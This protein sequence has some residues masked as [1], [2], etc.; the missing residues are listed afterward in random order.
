MINNSSPNSQ[1]PNQNSSLA[2]SDNKLNKLSYLNRVNLEYVESLMGQYLEN[3]E[4]V[5]PIWQKFFEGV[6][7][8]QSG[9]LQIGEA[10]DQASPELKVY[11]LIQAYRDY[12]HLKADLDPLKLQNRKTSFLDFKSFNLSESD[13]S[14]TFSMG[15]ILGLGP[16]TLSE[17]IDQLEKWYCQTLTV[18]MAECHP[19]VRDWFT[20]EMESE[21]VALSKD[22]KI[23]VLKQLIRTETLEKF[24]HTRYVGTKRFSIEGCDSLIPCLEYLCE[25]GAGLGVKAVTIGMAHRGRINVLANFMDK[26]LNIIFAEFDGNMG[27]DQT[28]D[29]DG[30][31]KYHL[32]YHSIKETKNGP[33]DISLAFNPSHLEAVNPVVLGMVRAQQ[34]F[35]HD[36]EERKTVV[37]VLIHGD[38]AVIGQG[39]VSETFQLSLL[40][41]YTVGGTIHIVMNNQVGFTTDPKDARSTDYASDIAKSIKAPILHVNGDDPE[42]CVKAMDIA[43]RFRQQF[44][45]DVVIE[46]VGYRRFGHNEGDE[47]AFTQPKMYEVIKKLP[48]TY[49]L[50][51]SKLNKDQI[52]S[53]AQSQ[54]F[55]DLKMDNLQKVLDEVRTN[56]PIVTHAPMPE[57]WKALKRGMTADAFVPVNTKAKKS[58]L[59]KVIK[60]IT[61]YPKGF[62]P[63][64]KVLKLLET[65]AK[66]FQD[67]SIDWGLAELLAYGTLMTEG[68][69]VR[70]T[71]QDCIRGTFTHR[72]AMFFDKD[73]GEV[74][75]PFKALNP[76]KEFCVYNS[77]LSEY[78]VLGFEYGNAI[79]DPSFLTLWEAQFGDFVNGAQII[80]DQFISSGESKWYQM[81]GLVLLLPHGYEGQGPEHSSARLERFLQQCAQYNMQVCNFT[82]PN[83]LFHALRRQIKR[84]FRKPMIVMSPKSLLRN[85]KVVCKQSDLYEGQFSEVLDDPR[86]VSK[87]V[88]TGS[89]SLPDS[90]ALSKEDVQRVVMCSGKVYYDLEG[91]D[92]LSQKVA[93]VRVEQ[94]YPFPEQ[95]VAD[96]LATYPRMTE[97]LWTQ[98][99]PQNMGAYSFI[100]PKLRMCLQRLKKSEV[101]AYYVG[102]TERASPATGSPSVHAKE[103]Q[104]I[105]SQSL[106]A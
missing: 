22:Q 48:T 43:I 10:M 99:E 42:A 98:E 41:G 49:S 102:R 97:L 13:A 2:G 79:K 36:T 56:T 95:Q 37:P 17:I 84:N 6:E 50:Y 5:D 46:I 90:P 18:Q 35:N 93:L 94:L 63:H 82:E 21:N 55:Y 24:L 32:G 100:M 7:F 9:R 31:V 57:K 81:N 65:R 61:S 33:V 51:A 72:H 62:N 16:K 103:Q 30:D 87:K 86:F 83:Q 101:P 3:P 27:V 105:I 60:E 66:Q 25:K 104:L 89:M 4:S 20:K 44:K 39:V 29:Y 78:A 92:K 70:L 54:E 88:Q 45:Q 68:T 11:E 59:E 19:Q 52:F 47:P 85:P 1:A 69:S 12:G 91:S 76:E 64:S 28:H 38:A 73:T 40:K 26:A 75:N 34:R 106:E 15:Q 23:N 74:H 96:I 14:K 67:D 8:G 58:D 53:T 80:I 77:P 71:G